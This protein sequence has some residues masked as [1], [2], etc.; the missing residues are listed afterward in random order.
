M[1]SGCLSGSRRL[2]DEAGGSG[3]GPVE[4]LG[5]RRPRASSRFSRLVAP[6][7]AAGVAQRD[8]SY[9]TTV[10]PIRYGRPMRGLRAELR[11]QL[12][13]LGAESRRPSTVP[14][15]SMTGCWDG[16]VRTA[17]MS[18]GGASITPGDGRLLLVVDRGRSTSFVLSAVGSAISPARPAGLEG[19]VGEL[20]HPASSR[21]AP[22]RGVR[23]AQQLPGQARRPAA[24]SA[25]TQGDGKEGGA[26]EDVARR[27][28][29]GTRRSWPP[30]RDR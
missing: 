24:A 18:S 13:P 4:R 19:R 6:A 10:L 5:D 25:R 28:G 26:P 3:H 23:G 14:D 8:A 21:R 1:F 9:S 11:A 20:V 16:S 22:A 17:K 27:V 29:A 15:P 2:L 7:V 12:Q 30:G